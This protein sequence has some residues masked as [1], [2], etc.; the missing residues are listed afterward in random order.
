ME[1]NAKHRCAKCNATFVDNAHLKRHQQRKTP[2]DLIVDQ[3]AADKTAFKCRFCGRHYSSKPSVNRHIRQSCKVANSEE[4]MERLFEH[5]IQ[6]QVAAMHAEQNAKIAAQTQQIA[7]LTQLVRN[8]IVPARG[9]VQRAATINNVTTTNTIIITVP[10]TQERAVYIPASMLRA[11]FTENPKL[12][13]YCGWSDEDKTNAERAVPYVLEA[14]M[15]LTRR[16]HADPAAR[17]I[18]L[19]PRRADQVMV[20]DE[21]SWRVLTLVDAI[22]VIFN[23]VSDN[24][25]RIMRNREEVATLPLHI[26]GSASWIPTLY[27]YEQSEYV[28]KARASMSAHLQNLVETARREPAAANLPR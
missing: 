2:C 23:S 8:Q 24:I 13:E 15:E 1:D 20:L 14:L 3:G 4:G 21:E 22:A 10:F 18:Y 12:A 25:R 9:G 5:T 16:A 7:E 11:A 27:E 28:E 6:R 26:Q 19:N 17:N